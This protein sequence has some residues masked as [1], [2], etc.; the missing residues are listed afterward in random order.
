MGKNLSEG[1][2]MKS[3][4]LKGFNLSKVNE[5]KRDLDLYSLVLELGESDSGLEKYEKYCNIKN[6]CEYYE[7]TIVRNISEKYKNDYNFYIYALYF[8]NLPQVEVLFDAM[9]E[10]L[11]NN[12]DFA[13]IIYEIGYK[14]FN[15][16]HCD[17]T[18]SL[19]GDIYGDII[20]YFNEVVTMDKEVCEFVVKHDAFGFAYSNMRH[21]NLN[22][23]S[24]RFDEE[25]VSNIDNLAEAIINYDRYVQENKPEEVIEI[26]PNKEG[27]ESIANLVAQKTQGQEP[28][29]VRTIRKL[30]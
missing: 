6:S 10:D 18:I 8:Y 30:K 25:V 1:F 24:P 26:I 22:N 12:K 14:I 17:E 7:E 23:I 15:G 28:S 11:K 29:L 20:C 21:H 16:Y 2:E 13:K 3:E 9:S 5:Y 4:L 27:L 19:S